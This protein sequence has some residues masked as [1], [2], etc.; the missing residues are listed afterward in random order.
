MLVKIYPV[1]P[2]EKHIAQ[3][4]RCLEDGGVVIYPTD[5]VYGFGCS[6]HSPRGVERLLAITGKQLGTLA[7]VCEDL[8]RVADYA[9]VD[10]PAFKLLKRNLPGPFTFILKPS[11]KVPDKALGKRKSIGV[12]IPANPIP[13]AIVSA[14]GCPMLTTSVKDPDQVV[15]YTTD[16][17]L[18]EE[19]Y[20]NIVQM[21]VDGGYGDNHP[22][23][24]VDLTSDD[25]PVIVRQG[26]GE[27]L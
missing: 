17:E 26:K 4:V 12:R 19:R 24:L 6:L 8:S 3:V 11:S 21:V 9:R 15:E 18:I 23:T 14:L 5:S 22:T 27:L 20:E 25:E 16:P 2:N 7:L 10:N 13:L 1:N